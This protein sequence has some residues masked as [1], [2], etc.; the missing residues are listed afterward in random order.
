MSTDQHFALTYPLPVAGP[1]TVRLQCRPD[2]GVAPWTS[3]AFLPR[4]L[5]SLT[6]HVTQFLLNSLSMGLGS[7]GFIHPLPIIY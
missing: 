6:K 2:V 5:L 3:L 1:G 4:S 7:I